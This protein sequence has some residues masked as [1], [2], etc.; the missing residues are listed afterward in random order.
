MRIDL[1]GDPYT[2][3][4]RTLAALVEETGAEAGA[5]ATALDGAFVPRGLRAKTALRAGVRVEI[6]SPMQGG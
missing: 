4:S 5:V 1:N 6:L 3:R 2:T